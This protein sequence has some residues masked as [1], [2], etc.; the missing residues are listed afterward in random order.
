MRAVL[1]AL[2]LCLTASAASASAKLELVTQTANILTLN[3]GCVYAP[4]QFAHGDT[5]T[6]AYAIA[7]ATTICPLAVRLQQ[8]GDVQIAP[9]Y[10]VGVYR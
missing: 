4:A 10:L 9:G 6:F 2:A 5:W 7:S 8:G 3:N 1:I